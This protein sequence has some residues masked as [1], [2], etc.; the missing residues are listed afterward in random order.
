MLFALVVVCGMVPA[1]ARVSAADSTKPDTKVSNGKALFDLEKSAPA[2]LEKYPD[3]VYDVDRGE[4]FLLSE[5]NELGLFVTKK[6]SKA[7]FRM[8]N[9]NMAMTKVDED[10]TTWWMASMYLTG[11]ALAENQVFSKR[12]RSAAYSYIKIIRYHHTIQ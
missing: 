10:G 9:L 1:G 5:Q 6:D 7:M 2:E 12:R 4:A 8:D 11:R 3:N